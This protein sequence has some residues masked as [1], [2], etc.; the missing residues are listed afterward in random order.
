PLL[1]PESGQHPILKHSSWLDCFKTQRS[2]LVSSCLE[3]LRDLVLESEL[4]I[5]AGD[6]RE[7]LRRWRLP[8][9]PGCDAV[10]GQLR[11]V[12]DH[13]PK[14]G[15]TENRSVLRKHHLY[16]DREAILP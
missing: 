13:G 8:C 5:E 2:L 3:P 9:E 12:A 11:V 15:R 14:E 1:D 16:D 4:R 6:G 7:P 10:I